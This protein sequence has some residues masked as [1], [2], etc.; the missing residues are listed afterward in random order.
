MNF[1]GHCAV[2][3]WVAPEPAFA[4]GAML[5]DLANM[6]GQRH[7]ESSDHLLAQGIA[8][9]HRTDA[10]FHDSPTFVRLQRM[11]RRVL[12]STG[13][14]R[15]PSLAVAHIGLEILLDA[16]LAGEKR[17]RLHYQRALESLEL[18]TARRVLDWGRPDGDSWSQFDALRHRLLLRQTQLAPRTPEQLFQRLSFILAGRPA[19][20]LRPEHQD[21]VVAWAETASRQ[22]VEQ[23][24]GWL[25]ELRVGLRLPSRQ[26]P[27]N[28][29]P[30]LAPESR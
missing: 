16:R 13:V 22:V 10:V 30:S 26:T 8:F 4:L 20:A 14:D 29:A 6:I 21:S 3:S 7:I 17:Y 15:G 11:A 12:Q 18:E 9:H 5:P 1:F 25:A 27:V 19:L 24:E 23:L 28:V 2:A